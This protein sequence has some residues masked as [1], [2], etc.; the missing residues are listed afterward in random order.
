MQGFTKSDDMRSFVKLIIR[1]MFELICTPG[2]GPFVVLFSGVSKG[3]L[4]VLEH[5]PKAKECS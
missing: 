2:F 1:A 3:V 4:R 5:P